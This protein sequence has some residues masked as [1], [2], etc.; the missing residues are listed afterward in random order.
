MPMAKQSYNP[1]EMLN[2]AR[3][4]KAIRETVKS[5]DDIDSNA[6]SYHIVLNFV[7]NTISATEE[8][9]NILSKSLDDPSSGEQLK[10]IILTLLSKYTVPLEQKLMNKYVNQIYEDMTGFGILTPY[11][12]DPNVEEINIYGPGTRQIE[13]I[14][15]KDGAKMLEDGFNDA[16]AVIDVVKRMVRK[17][18]TVID[19]SNPRVDSYMDGGTRISAMIAPVIRDDRGAVASIRKQTKSSITLEDFLKSQTAME[20]EF[21]FIKLC[22]RNKISGAIV[23]ATGSGK[24]TLLNYIMTDYVNNAQEQ[25]RVY[26]IEES[27][28]LQLPSDARAIYTAVVGDGNV[29]VTAPDLL[30]SAL[31]FHPT[32]ISCA[33]MRGEEAMNAMTAAQTGHIV[34]STFHAD[35]CEDSYQRLLTMCKMSGTDLSEHLLMRNIVQAFPIIVSSQQLKDGKRKITGIYEA[36]YVDGVTVVGHYIYK[37]Q[38]E[39]YDYNEDGSVKKVNGFHSR[40]GDLSDK[41]AQRIFDNCGLVDVVKK[42][43]RPDWEPEKINFDQSQINRAYEEF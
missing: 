41:M 23:G 20:E 42:F 4:D 5:A 1:L 26:I 8:Y 12:D 7:Q 38:V 14:S 24:T 29:N 31:R 15:S 22:T 30:K 37:L 17:G 25:T 32:F 34:W 35:N 28:E 36:D 43:A 13:V 10:N 18:N 11:L 2:I 33:E 19:R 21:E 9:R 16:Q 39:S 3:Q 27:R 6:T 40:V